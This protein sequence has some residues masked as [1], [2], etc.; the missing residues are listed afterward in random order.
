MT[1]TLINN[2]N[3]RLHT[4]FFR[5]VLKRVLI[6]YYD[7]L[8]YLLYSTNE[9]TY[10]NLKYLQHKELCLDCCTARTH[11]FVALHLSEIGKAQYIH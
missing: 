10:Q 8:T 3:T 11:F 5:L 2:R 4:D 1:F 6:V 9:K 7:I